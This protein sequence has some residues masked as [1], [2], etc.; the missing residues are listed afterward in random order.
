LNP[1]RRLWTRKVAKVVLTTNVER[2][3]RLTRTQSKEVKVEARQMSDY[4]QSQ[5]EICVSTA[6]RNMPSVGDPQYEQKACRVY[7]TFYDCIRSAVTTCDVPELNQAIEEFRVEGLTVCPNEF[8][9]T[10]R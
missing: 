5:A 6:R 9:G 10:G 8:S 7:R 3:E 1:R 2:V 4:C